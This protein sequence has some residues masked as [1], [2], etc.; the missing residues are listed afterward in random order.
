[1]KPSRLQDHLN[2]MYSDKK[3]K[4][5]A[6]FQDL[7]K[8]YIAQPTVSKLFLAA[9][10]Q[11]DDGLRASYNIFLLIAQRGKPHTIGEELILQAIKGV[12]TTVLHKNVADIIRKIHL[13]NSSVQIRIDEMAENIEESLCNHLKTSQFSI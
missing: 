10:N 12:I 7:E 2:K 13:S 9:A 4:N 3:D 11:D 8:K 1:M 6:Y 5:G